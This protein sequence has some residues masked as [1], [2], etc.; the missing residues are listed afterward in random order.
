MS[1]QV[2]FRFRDLLIDLVEWP[3]FD[4]ITIVVIMMNCI[5]LAMYDPF[6]EDCV[7]QK[8]KILSYFDL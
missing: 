4:S 6:D 7:T 1:E 2:L 5:T 3:M 8:C